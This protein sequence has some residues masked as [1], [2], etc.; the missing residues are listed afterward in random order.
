MGVIDVVV[1]TGF[2]T[3]WGDVAVPFVCDCVLSEECC[4]AGVPCGAVAVP[5]DVVDVPCVVCVVG[6]LTAGAVSDAGCSSLWI[7]LSPV[8]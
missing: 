7:R 2:S 4:S 1:G 3:V 8:L 5:C 6:A